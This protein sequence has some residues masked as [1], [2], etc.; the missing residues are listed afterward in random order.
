[1]KYKGGQGVVTTYVSW[2]RVLVSGAGT[3]PRVGFVKFQNVGYGT[4]RRS[5]QKL[6][7]GM[8]T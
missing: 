2:P 3:D 7:M 6:N 4:L 1:M 8:W 5:I